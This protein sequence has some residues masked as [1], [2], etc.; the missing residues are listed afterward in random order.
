MRAHNFRTACNT[1]G[2]RQK[3]YTWDGGIGASFVPVS[4]HCCVF[5]SQLHH[6]HIVK[7][8]GSAVDGSNMYIFTKWV[9][10]GSLQALVQSFGALVP[11]VAVRYIAQALLAL[12]HIHSLGLVHRDV[13]VRLTACTAPC[14]NTQSHPHTHE[15]LCSPVI[16]WWTTPEQC[17]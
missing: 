16:S 14:R 10:G 6:T 9:S 12:S 2:S 8:L 11:Q 3:Q 1:P 17:S 13:K 15:H 5:R 4:A 7:Y